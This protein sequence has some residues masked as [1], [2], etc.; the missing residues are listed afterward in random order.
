[1][2]SDSVNTYTPTHYFSKVGK[3]EDYLKLRLVI[4]TILTASMN[5]Y[6]EPDDDVVGTALAQADELLQQ[7]GFSH[8]DSL[9]PA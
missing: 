4:A 9:P 6:P 2:A 5:L 7:C 8:P 3:V 1:M